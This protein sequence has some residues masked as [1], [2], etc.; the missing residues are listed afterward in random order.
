[1][2]IRQLF[3]AENRSAIEDW[4]Q[5]KA[6]VCYQGDHTAFVRTLGNFLLYVDTRDHS[7]APHLQ[8]DGFWE[9]W[10]TQAIVEY[11]RPGMCCVD[12]GANFGYYT[13]LL[14]ELTGSAGQVTAYEPQKRV[15]DLLRRSIL[16]NGADAWTFG[17]RMAAANVEGHGQLY[18]NDELMGSASLTQT[19]RLFPEYEVPLVLLDRQPIRRP[20]DFVKIDAQGHELQ[21]LEGM[22]G[23]IRES[24]KIAIAMEFSPGEHED[25]KAAI[26]TILSYGL[27]LRAIGTDGQVR[28]VSPADAA[29]ADTGDHRMLWLSKG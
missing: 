8:A 12:V 29:K 15:H 22:Q 10:V 11:V 26:E 2:K 25:P 24:K 7:L 28:A 14:A 23:I 19:E 5:A 21:V 6:K 13:L 4:C 20:V 16:V 1:M 18:V 17:R 27:T 9:M 3:Q